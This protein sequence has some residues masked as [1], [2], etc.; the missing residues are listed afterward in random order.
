M[1]DLVDRLR[2]LA[3]FWSLDFDTADEQHLPTAKTCHEAVDRIKELEAFVR[4]AIC[5]NA[6]CHGKPVPMGT[7]FC[8]DQCLDKDRLLGGDGSGLSSCKNH[9]A[10]NR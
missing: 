10:A 3:N 9:R 5:C 1:S 8:C 4:E 7:L 6:D 2:S